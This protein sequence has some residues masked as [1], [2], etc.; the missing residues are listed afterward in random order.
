MQM[1]SSWADWFINN[2]S[3]DAGN[4]NLQAFSE[5]LSSGDS[6]KAKLQALVEKID[7]VILAAD[8]N[9]DI[10]I[11]HSPKNFGGTRSHPKNK[12]VCMLGVGPQAICILLDLNTVFRD[13][14][15][16]SHQFTT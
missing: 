14:Q 6:N 11:L 10:M 3:N 15:L 9:G 7:T 1:H 12:V 8:S 16:L 4:R 13:I 5:I 2:K